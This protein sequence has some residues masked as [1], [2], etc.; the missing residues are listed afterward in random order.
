MAGTHHLT[1]GYV[2]F[3]EL[4]YVY[5]YRK[6]VKIIHFHFFLKRNTICHILIL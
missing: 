4:F 3:Y 2:Y 6:Y 5:L 1:I